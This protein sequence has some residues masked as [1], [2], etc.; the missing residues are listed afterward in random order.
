[1]RNKIVLGA[2]LVVI[3]ALIGG[4]L[5]ARAVFTGDNVRATLA[6]QVSK[7]I[8]QPVTIGRVA[9]FYE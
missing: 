1:M 3:I 7:A 4:L 6:A 2:G 9:I 5:W 8:G